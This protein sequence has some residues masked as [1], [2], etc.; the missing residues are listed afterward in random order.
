MSGYSSLLIQNNNETGQPIVTDNHFTVIR[1]S[2][3]AHTLLLSAS[4]NKHV[5]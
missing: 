4:L 1:C 5:N 3:R 2:V